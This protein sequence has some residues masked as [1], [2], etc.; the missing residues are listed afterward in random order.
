M[1]SSKVAQSLKNYGHF[2]DLGVGLLSVTASLDFSG[3]ANTSIRGLGEDDTARH[4]V[5]LSLQT[6][7]QHAL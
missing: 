2:L 4:D 7:V 6:A 1:F 5:G 3:K